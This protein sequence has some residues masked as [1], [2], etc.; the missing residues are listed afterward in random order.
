MDVAHR[1]VELVDTELLGVLWLVS[2]YELDVAGGTA[3][4]LVNLQAK[5]EPLGLVLSLI[6]H[7]LPLDDSAEL[8]LG[9]CVHPQNPPLGDRL[10]FRAD[11]CAPPVRQPNTRDSDH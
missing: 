11:A 10:P 8:L 4:V 7:Q 3:I 6:G 2:P 9:E 1:V 5:P